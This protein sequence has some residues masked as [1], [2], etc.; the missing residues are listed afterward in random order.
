MQADMVL[1][2]E[3]SVLQLDPQVLERA[4][5][6]FLTSKPTPTMTHFLQQGHTPPDS[7]TLYGPSI[8]M[9]NSMGVILI[10]TTT[11]YT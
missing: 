4:D 5:L 9:Q 3:L 7:A 6:S 11:A 8:Q 10:Q 2:K 1:E